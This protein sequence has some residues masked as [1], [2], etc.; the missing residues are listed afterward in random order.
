NRL[1]AW[2]ELLIGNREDGS[3]KLLFVLVEHLHDVTI[4]GEIGKLEN[5]CAGRQCHTGNLHWSA[6]RQNRF[7]VPFVSTGGGREKRRQRHCA[8]NSFDP[9]HEFASFSPLALIVGKVH[10]QCRH[11]TFKR[12][13]IAAR[14]YSTRSCAQLLL[15][16]ERF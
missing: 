4:A 12:L 3:V 1:V 14:Q 7:L 6:E 11:V 16:S 15:R 8:T 5:V 13:R 9:S 2:F 10:M